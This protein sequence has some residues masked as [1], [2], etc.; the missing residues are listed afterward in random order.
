MIEFVFLRLMMWIGLPLALA[1]LAIG[2]K[3]AKRMW[4]DAWHWLTDKRLPPE[5]ILANVVQQHQQQIAAMRKSL[6]QARATE[7]EIEL[8]LKHS[9]ESVELLDKEIKKLAS[10]GDMLGLAAARYKQQLERSAVTTFASQI[11]QQHVHI[12]E[13]Q[14]RLY[15][16]ELQ[17]RQFEIGRNILLGQLSAAKNVQQQVTIVDQF[18]PF[19]A[20]ADW[21]KAEGMV[22]DQTLRAKA[23]ERVHADLARL[24]GKDA[25]PPLDAQVID[26]PPTDNGREAT[27]TDQPPRARETQ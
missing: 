23:L 24:T 11:E 20:M 22:V 16:V 14:R 9:Q 2:P 5:Q 10:D 4:H 15:E 12:V 6:A 19:N 13:A 26:N 7:R 8:N 27:D 3:R 25:S 18:D 1:I 21:R 17:L